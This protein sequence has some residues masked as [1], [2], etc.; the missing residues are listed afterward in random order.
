MNRRNYLKLSTATV[1]SVGCGNLFVST[2]GF[3]A[4]TT[5]DPCPLPLVT[6]DSGTAV[7]SRSR[8]WA[9]YSING[10]VE[11]RYFTSDWTAWGI[12]SGGPVPQASVPATKTIGATPN[13]CT[14]SSKK[15]GN[16]TWDAELTVQPPGPT[17]SFRSSILDALPANARLATDS[18]ALEAQMD[19]T[20]TI[21][22]TGSKGWARTIT[23]QTRGACS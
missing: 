7:Y 6:N 5:A 20:G 22:D 4:G 12:V 1:C 8:S 14:Y 9:L 21:T 18:E 17:P 2:T 13:R 10:A 19:K 16:T 3:A 11:G 23:Y 15:V